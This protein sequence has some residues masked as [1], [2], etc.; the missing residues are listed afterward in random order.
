M[1]YLTKSFY[2][3]YPGGVKDIDKEIAKFINDNNTPG[4]KISQIQTTGLKIG[5]LFIIVVLE[6][7]LIS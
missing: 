2:F 6:I 4:M 5:A 1:G 3:T 7:N